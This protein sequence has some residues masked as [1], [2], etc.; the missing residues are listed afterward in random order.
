MVLF[1]LAPVIDPLR[2]NSGYVPLAISNITESETPQLYKI[3]TAAAIDEK[4][5]ETFPT[6][7]VPARGPEHPKMI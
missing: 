5:E 2:I 1:A 4:V 6:V 3:L 7:K